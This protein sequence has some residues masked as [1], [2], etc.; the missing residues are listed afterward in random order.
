VSG[1]L[2]LGEA[3]RAASEKGP[4]LQALG[5]RRPA[6]RRCVSAGCGRDRLYSRDF[7]AS[8]LDGEVTVTRAC[9]FLVCLVV[10][11]GSGT[12]AAQLVKQSVRPRKVPHNSALDPGKAT[13]FG[14]IDSNTEAIDKLS[15]ELWNEPELSFREFKTSR[16]LMRYLESNGF[17]VEQN[18]GGLTTAF[19]ASYG[20]GTPIIA[21]WA[22]Y[23]ALAGL[24]QKAEPVREPVISGGPG[25]ACGHS[26][27]AAG[28]AAAAV[29]V[30]ASMQRHGIIGT[31]RFYG[32][33]AEE[34]G[35]GKD[36][37]LEAGVF[38]DADVL[39][40]WHTSNR[41][42]TEFEYSKAEAEMHFHFKGVA[43]H[44]SVSPWLGRSALHAAELMDAGVN[45]T[46]EQL[47]EDA[48][49]QYVISNGGGQPNV[50]PADAESWY[51]IRADKN[52][53]VADIVQWVSEIA[54]GAAMMTR[55]QVDIR[56]DA[57]NHEVLPNGPLAEVLDRN[58]RLV[59]APHYT[60]EEGANARKML[61]GMKGDP[62]YDSP[63]VVPLPLSP[64]QGAYS[65][66]LG[67]VS[68]NVPTERFVVADSPYTL[69]VHGWQAAANAAATGLKTIPVG[70][71]TLAAAAMDL[72]KDPALVSAAKHDFDKRK[73]GY[74][75]SVLTPPNRKAP[76][77]VERSTGIS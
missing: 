9:R 60:S 2:D 8:P 69:N 72:F 66:D 29:A 70:A 6:N 34:V 75:Y 18:A 13:A 50:I 54:K 26:L 76:V 73:K 68:W 39:L 38:K 44:A 71:K 22:E 25:H 57:D 42:R 55:T 30:A 20:S 65:T 23:D 11:F 32:T 48:R 10:L 28:T 43:T 64:T 24:S 56:V 31:L 52:D 45:Y 47:K 1:R 53:E 77:Y 62:E 15:L 41:T 59:G 3:C 12:L 17:T 40:G 49:V 46:R 63:K 19:V 27:E 58:L 33:P 67:N 14:W 37:M 36:Y 74:P 61:E 16:T 21:F 7:G 51:V 4:P 5:Q 35:S